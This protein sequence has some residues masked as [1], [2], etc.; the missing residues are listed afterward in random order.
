[1]QKE[2]QEMPLFYLE[3]N[4]KA[5]EAF[6]SQKKIIPA[7]FTRKEVEDEFISKIHSYVC[8]QKKLDMSAI[9]GDV[10]IKKTR[11]IIFRNGESPEF[12][13]NDY[14]IS[15]IHVHGTPTDEHC[16]KISKEQARE[17]ELK[18]SKFK[19]SP[20]DSGGIETEGSIV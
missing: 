1:M 2:S 7:T 18:E 10:W 5:I 6:N 19:P 4:G 20:I 14:S 12:K 13:H 16:I 8:T 11:K 15:Y 17:I 3:V 9:S